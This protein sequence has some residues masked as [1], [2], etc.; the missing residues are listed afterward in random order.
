VRG[1]NVEC[2]VVTGTEPLNAPPIIPKAWLTISMHNN[3]VPIVGPKTR[4][5]GIFVANK[6]LVTEYG[7]LKGVTILEVP[8]TEIAEKMGNVQGAAM[9]LL[10]AVCHATGLTTVDQ[11]I[12]GLKALTPP[13]R[14]KTL[15]DNVKAFRAGEAWAKEQLKNFKQQ[16]WA[17]AAA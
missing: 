4:Q 16:A 10:A 6:P 11:L 7:N 14:Q 13:Y 17:K 8:A 1:G 5:G 3:T 9:V 2:T 12:E 15:P